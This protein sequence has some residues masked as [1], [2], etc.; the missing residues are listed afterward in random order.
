MPSAQPST[1]PPGKAILGGHEKAR[2]RYEERLKY[3]GSL[4]AYEYSNL[5]PIIGREIPSLQ[6]TKILGS[7]DADTLV[8]DLAITSK[9]SCSLHL[10][11]TNIHL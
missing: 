9:S 4:D 5:T 11:A 1:P 7:P 6:I 2:P 10:K 8:R 3:S